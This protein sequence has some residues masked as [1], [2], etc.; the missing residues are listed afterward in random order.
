MA[1]SLRSSKWIVPSRLRRGRSA[2]A[3]DL[4]ARAEGQRVRGG[5]GL[6]QRIGAPSRT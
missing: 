4:I 1:R 6:F 2:E 5:K 3:Y